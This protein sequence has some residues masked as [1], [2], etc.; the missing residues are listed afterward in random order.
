MSNRTGRTLAD[1]MGPIDGDDE[2]PEIASDTQ[3]TATNAQPKI[4]PVSILVTPEDRR[5]LRQ[6]SLDSNL[7]V[8]KLG[9]EALNMMLEARGLSPLEPVTANIPSGRSRRS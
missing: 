5:R 7:S 3:A 8:Q 6:L 4:V 1:V 2:M 9:H